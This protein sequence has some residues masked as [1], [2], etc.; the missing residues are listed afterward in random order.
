M[1]I[2][3][4]CSNDSNETVCTYI[5][6]VD[7]TTVDA[8]FAIFKLFGGW[9]GVIIFLALVVIVTSAV[10]PI[11]RSFFELFWYTHHLFIVFFVF[12]IT[13]GYGRQIRGQT[14]L[15][16]HNPHDCEDLHDQWGDA[17]GCPLP[18]F[19][20]SP[21]ATWKWVVVPCG[22][23]F[24]ER[25]IRVYHAVFPAQISKIVMHPSRVVE[26]QLNKHK[27]SLRGDYND[28]GEYIFIKVQLSRFL[29]LKTITFSARLFLTLSGIPS[30]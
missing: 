17:A 15:A 9:S 10:E 21:P 24:I 22:V 13:H 16:E 30:L 11:R 12:L 18:Q 26:I 20:G 7:E 25:L 1:L 28:V 4:D 29:T 6:P 19:A 3:G 23:Y 8:E 14:N 5:N 2:D 27:Y